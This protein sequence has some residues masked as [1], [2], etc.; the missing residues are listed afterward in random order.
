MSF[1]SDVTRE[2]N[3]RPQLSEIFLR[4]QNRIP[5][6]LKYLKHESST[7]V[8]LMPSGLYFPN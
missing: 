4:K 7:M 2:V 3:I 5:E 6:N 8:E 1:N